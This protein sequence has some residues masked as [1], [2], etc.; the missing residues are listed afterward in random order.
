MTEFAS[1]MGVH[2]MQSRKE[3]M[4]V[5]LKVTRR[6]FA[7]AALHEIRIHERVKAAGHG[8]CR[9]ISQVRESFMHEGHVC[10]AF[11]FHGRDLTH[12]LRGGAMRLRDAKAVTRQL[13]AGLAL[14]HE[15]GVIHTDVKPD[16]ILYDA[17]TGVARLSDLGLSETSLT[18]GEPIATQD[19]A[20]PEALTGVHMAKPVDLW[21]LGCTVF[22]ML[23]GELLFDPWAACRAKYQEF[24]DDDDEG[25]DAVGEI[26]L[27]DDEPPSREALDAAE[28]EREQLLPG[29]IIAGKYR[30]L[31][32]LGQGKF[33]TVW[34]TVPLHHAG[35]MLPSSEEVVAR[36]KALRAELPPLPP[37]ARWNL[38]DVA[39]AYEHLLQMHELLGP[40]PAHILQGC[41][42]TLFCDQQLGLRFSPVIGRRTL[43]ERL[44]GKIAE[45][46][47]ATL[48]SFLEGLLKYAPESRMTAQEALAH[49]WLSEG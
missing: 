32:K 8:E 6:R 49:P 45:D 29:A 22:E 19:Y 39:Q 24:G 35:L 34:E 46:E 16:N 42:Q 28:E 23:T 2:S 3:G 44:A 1:F 5:A 36:A 15:S 41:W 17:A 11:D 25:D 31:R 7:S 38:Y 21:A 13:L 12:H 20:P 9:H 18:T 27:I 26:E 33:A 43:R 40:A 4:S 48:A 10:M 30:L 14:L 37:R 47:I